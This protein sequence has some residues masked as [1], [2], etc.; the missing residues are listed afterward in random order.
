[1]IAEQ[2]LL[3]FSQMGYAILPMHDSFILHHGLEDELR[4]SMN[5]AFKVMFGVSCR[6]DLKYNSIDKRHT[7]E[8]DEPDVN[9][10]D[11]HELVESFEE[12]KTYEELLN[13]HRRIQEIDRPS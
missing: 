5:E 9:D 11:L 10:M 1:M 7:E 2:V 6:I 8:T 12:Y 13:E 4:E 3:H